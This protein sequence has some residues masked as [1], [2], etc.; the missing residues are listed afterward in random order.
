MI[1]DTIFSRERIC[2]LFMWILSS[3]TGSSRAISHSSHPVVRGWGVEGVGRRV[4]V[5]GAP[6]S[7]APGAG[8]APAAPRPEPAHHA[9]FSVGVPIRTIRYSRR[10]RRIALFHLH[11]AWRPVL[12]VTRDLAADTSLVRSHKDTTRKPQNKAVTIPTIKKCPKRVQFMRAIPN[13]R[14]CKHTPTV[15]L[16]CG[17]ARRRGISQSTLRTPTSAMRLSYLDA[18]AVGLPA[19][20]LPWRRRRLPQGRGRPPT[21]EPG[22]QAR[23]R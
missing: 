1:V 18:G 10:V 23:R 17:R 22:G 2:G 11:A 3:S 5:G 21:D 9:A 12:A 7:A 16:Q 8:G 20:C 19:A 15:D 13:T 6:P 14:A 4:A